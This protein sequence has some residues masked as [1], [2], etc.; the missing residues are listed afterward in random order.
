MNKV[1]TKCWIKLPAVNWKFNKFDIFL[2]LTLY[3]EYGKKTGLILGWKTDPCLFHYCDV[4]PS[5]K[6]KDPNILGHHPRRKSSSFSWLSSSPNLSIISFLQ[7][8][9]RPTYHTALTLGSVEKEELDSSLPCQLLISKGFVSILPLFSNDPLAS[10]L[11]RH[12]P[13]TLFRFRFNTR[14]TPPQHLEDEGSWLT[15]PW[16]DQSGKKPPHW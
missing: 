1:L 9:P 5:V 15:G 3:L 13:L 12:L 16:A 14:Q 6:S 10:S 11:L 8:L 7:T 2:L 4:V